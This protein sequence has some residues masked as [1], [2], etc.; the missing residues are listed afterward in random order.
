MIRDLTTASGFF[1]EKRLAVNV[2]DGKLTLEIGLKG[3]TT[4]TCI[5]WIRIRPRP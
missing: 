5:N 1:A 3:S 2:N 4:N